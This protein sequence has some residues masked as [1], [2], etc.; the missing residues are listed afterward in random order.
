MPVLFVGH[1]SPMNAIED[2]EYSRSW[3][4]MGKALPTPTAILCISA[5]WYIDGTHVLGTEKPETIYDF[6]GFPEKLYKQTYPAPGSPQLARTVQGLL[7]RT[8]VTW[9]LGWGFDHGTWSVTKRLFPEA[10]IP[11]IQL[12]IDYS[13]PSIFHYELGKKLAVLRSQG[14]LILGSGNIVHNLGIVRFEDDAKPFEWAEEFDA[15]ARTLLDTRDHKKLCDYESL[16]KA[17][18]LS[19]P[20]PEH[21]LPLLTSLGATSTKDELSYFCSGIE[22]GSVSMTACLFSEEPL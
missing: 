15:T 4:K 14:V 19:I 11:T 3:T 8:S 5:H 18:E 22:F 2:N 12:S 7:D 13:K 1:G 17:A 10:N 9:D 6:W 21:Y 16:G 20:T